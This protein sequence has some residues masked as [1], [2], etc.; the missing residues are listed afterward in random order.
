MHDNDILY[1]ILPHKKWYRKGWIL[2]ML[3]FIIIKQ[4]NLKDVDCFNYTSSPYFNCALGMYCSDGEK[5]P[6][7]GVFIF[8]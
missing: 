2:T 8:G 5:G 1:V 6:Q 3:F 7:V 4:F